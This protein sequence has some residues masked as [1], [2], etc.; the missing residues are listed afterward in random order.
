MLP[1]ENSP[2]RLV[3]IALEFLSQNLHLL[4]DVSL[5]RELCEA[6]INIHTT[7][8]RPV[9]LNFGKLFADTTKTKIKKICFKRSEVS[10]DG[11]QYLLRHKLTHLDVSQCHNPPNTLLQQISYHGENLIELSIGNW[12]KLQHFPGGFESLPNLRKLEIYKWH[13]FG[14]ALVLPVLLKPLTQLV[15][16][17]LSGAFGFKD[18]SCLANL[19]NIRCLILCRLK[20]NLENYNGISTIREMSGLTHLDI[21]GS[22]E[23]YSEPDETLASIVESLPKL[24]YLDI[25]ETNLAGRGTQNIPFL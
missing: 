14:N 4:E 19:P 9:D 16:L 15:S 21:S 10:R 22:D 13:D 25:S 23:P 17:N 2:E 6:F 8:G 18:L 3:N 11:L 20:N 1:F 24:V 12:K 5:P 7:A